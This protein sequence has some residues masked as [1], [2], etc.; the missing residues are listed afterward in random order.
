[1][2]GRLIL[3]IAALALSGCTMIPKYARP[4]PPVPPAWPEAAVAPVSGPGVA[5]VETP[6][7]Q[8]FTDRRLVGVIDLALQNNRDLRVATL[9]VEKLQAVYRIQRSELF[10]TVGVLATGEKV[11]I[12]GKET[13]NGVAKTTSAYSV[14]LGTS[15]WELD[16]FG[17]IRSLKAAALE[18]YLG[19]QH[20]RRG[21]QL[22]LV[23]AAA[24][25]WLALAADTESLELARATLE[26]QQASYDL[27][28]KSRDAGI[29]SDLDL[30]QAQTQVE[31]A[32]AALAA[33][34]GQ[35]ATD[36]ATLDVLAG[37][38]VPADLLPDRLGDV[39]EAKLLSPG[40]PSEVLL[41][42]PDILAAEHSLK[43]ANANIGAARAAFFPRISL[44][45]AVGTM[46]GELSG[47]FGSGTGT[48]T[49]VPQI[50]A[51]LFTGGYNKANLDAAN[52][53]REIAVAQYEKAI[54]GAFAEVTSGLTLRTTLVAQREAQEALVDALSE[55]YRLSDARYK[56]GIDSY[57]AVLVAQR[58]QFAGQQALINVR[59]AEQANLVTLYKVLGGGA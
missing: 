17:R 44:T 32:R 9:T 52:V 30:R 50:A 2:R 31:T 22:S 55:A 54:Q 1:M 34:A 7:Q 3:L 48:W 26:A 43:A 5:A 15:S 41:S 18:Q 49:F 46:S 45:A 58:S 8:F 40:L 33:F 29:A 37:T 28:Q 10:P 42:R 19:T 12:P 20:A 25:E 4:E 14:N 27:I 13:D 56:A 59:F 47:L 38:P 11:R 57:L 21:A 53:D 23:A 39:T 24:V 36:R 16:L 6:W 51:P 35:I